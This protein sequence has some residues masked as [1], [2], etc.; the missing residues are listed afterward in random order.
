MCQGGADEGCPPV[1]RLPRSPDE[2]K[3]RGEDG[4]AQMDLGGAE[5]PHF[6]GLLNEVEGVPAGFPPS[7]FSQP[8]EEHEPDLEQ[9][10]CLRGNEAT[11]AKQELW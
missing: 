7:P 10:G 5:H 2:R 9:Q 6:K 1:L 3:E 8:S 11:K 4:E